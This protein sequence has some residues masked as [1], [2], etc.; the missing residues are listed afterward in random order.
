V[1]PSDSFIIASYK[2][3][4]QSIR[5]KYP[6]ASIICALGNMDATRQGSPWP[7]YISQ[8]VS[9]LHDSK[10]YTHFFPFKNRG[11]HPNAHEQEVM[12][13]SLIDFIA[14]NIGW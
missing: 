4:V 9:Q 14:K 3:F 6:K 13:D 5:T 2:N 11:G 12:A 7:G 10:I 8:A 1:E